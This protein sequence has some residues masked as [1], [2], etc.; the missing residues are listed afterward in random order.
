MKCEHFKL[1]K[2]NH[3][4]EKVIVENVRRG[5]PFLSETI[6]LHNHIALWVGLTVHCG[7][8]TEWTPMNAIAPYKRHRPG[9][10]FLKS[11]R[12]NNKQTIYLLGHAS[13]MQLF[14][15]LAARSATSS[16]GKCWTLLEQIGHLYGDNLIAS[17]Q[18]MVKLV[19]KLKLSR[20][21]YDVIW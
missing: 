2:L 20:R 9:A 14:Q 8:N 16:T 10:Y 6:M 13:A 21:P 4:Q 1:Q 18:N 5:L 15:P 19:H 3:L 7:I 11:L 12:I 17:G